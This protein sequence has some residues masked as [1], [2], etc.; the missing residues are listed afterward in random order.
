[1]HVYKP[2]LATAHVGWMA[3]TCSIRARDTQ[4]RRI[5]FD[6]HQDDTES[7]HGHAR[8]KQIIEGHVSRRMLVN[9]CQVTWQGHVNP[10]FDGIETNEPDAL[11]RERVRL[12]SNLNKLV[13]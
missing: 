13:T 3:Q 6:I 7:H 11:H 12:R 9:A 2:S 8:F 1:M 10:S 5:Q 4:Q